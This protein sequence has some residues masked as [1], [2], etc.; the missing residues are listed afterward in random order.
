GRSRGGAHAQLAELLG[1]VAQAIVA[2]VQDVEVQRRIIERLR[3]LLAGAEDAR[4]PVVLEGKLLSA[5]SSTETSPS[6]E[7]QS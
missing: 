3:R 1:R 2:E 5:P 7:A 6:Q 4:E